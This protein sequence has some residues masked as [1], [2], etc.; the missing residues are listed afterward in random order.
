M[1]KVFFGNDTIRVRQQAL[2]A[3]ES[4][5]ESG[6]TLSVIDD[7]SYQ[8]GIFAD[9]AG[10]VSLFGGSQVYLIDTPSN[11][12]EMNEDT[13]AHLETFQTSS[14][15]FV[16]IEGVLLAADKKPF[17]KYAELIEEFKATGKERFNPFLLADALAARDKKN[18][19]L[20]LNEATLSGIML[21]ELVGTLWWQLKSLRLAAMTK[22]AAEAGMKDYP[23]NK[24]KRALG[25]F[26][27]G[28]IEALSHSLLRLQHDSRLGKRDLDLAL[29]AWVLKM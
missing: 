6:A 28:E 17:A 1:L 13:L 3:I 7:G 5:V 11:N 15:L 4:A 18:L 29:E 19:W 9:A 8:S 14:H 24:A 12:E 10:G 26:K 23:Y 2:K 16:V 20:L 25:K 27:E 21:E 22:S